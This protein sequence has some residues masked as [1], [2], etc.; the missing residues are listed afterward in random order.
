MCI[1]MYFLSDNA[2]VC[3]RNIR[4]NLSCKSMCLASAIAAKAKIAGL[5]PEE[6]GQRQFF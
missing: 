3:V 2:L 1:H 4:K 6:L 5:C